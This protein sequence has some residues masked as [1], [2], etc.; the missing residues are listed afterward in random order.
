MLIAGALL[1]GCGGDEREPPSA[2]PGPLVTY[3]REGGVAGI[4]EVMVVERDGQASIR[5]G[6]DGKRIGFELSADELD[7]LEAELEAADLDQVELDPDDVVCADCFTY[8][9]AA[10]GSEIAVNDLDRPP[11]AVATLLAHLG[12]IA[13]ANHPPAA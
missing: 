5:V 7:R 1:A 6:V 3:S 9:I 12:E 8:T 11:D 2:G 13:A 4:S 10:D